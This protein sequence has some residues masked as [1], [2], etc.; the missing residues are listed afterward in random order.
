MIITLTHMMFH[1]GSSEDEKGKF[2][3]GVAEKPHSND[4]IVEVDWD[5]DSQ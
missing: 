4:Q 5:I 2:S 1:R 3:H